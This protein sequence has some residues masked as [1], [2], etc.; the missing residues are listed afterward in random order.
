VQFEDF[1]SDALLFSLYV[2]VQLKPEISWTV[3]ASD[4][5]YM[6]YK[7]LTEHG[8]VMA[9]PQRDI[10][11]NNSRP[12]KIRVLADAPDIVSVKR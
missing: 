3:V 11:L 5:R 8:I 12:L 1:G 10:H 9:F 6:I 4:L 2:W 7:T